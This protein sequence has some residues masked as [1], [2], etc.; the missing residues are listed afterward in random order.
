MKVTTAELDALLA[1]FAERTTPAATAQLRA[2]LELMMVW[3]KRIDLTAARSAE[4]LVDLMV[5]DA[6]E[7][8][9]IIPQR[10]SVVDV[11]S[12]AG[13]PGLALALLRP[14]LEVTLVEP[15]TKRTSFLRNALIATARLDIKI[16]RERVDA[17][18]RKRHLFDWALS[19]AT[20]PPAEWLQVAPELLAQDGKIVLLTARELP[21]EAAGLTQASHVSYLWPHTQVE[22]TLTV[23]ARA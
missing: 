9:Q 20:L 5:A 8:A 18:L 1:V 21:P 7:L 22:R 14:D 6:L 11:G 4:E 12:G 16:E 23:Y 17:Y 3:N 2:W 13:A 10:A 19:R 15:L